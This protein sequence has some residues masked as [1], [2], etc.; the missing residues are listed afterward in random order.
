MGLL[1]GFQGFVKG[2]LQVLGDRVC[3]FVRVLEVRVLGL[4]VAPLSLGADSRRP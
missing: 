4:R 2:L 3:E 1:G